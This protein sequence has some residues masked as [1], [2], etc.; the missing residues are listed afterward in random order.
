M[1]QHTHRHAQEPTHARTHT[2]LVLNYACG[3]S[4]QCPCWVL[5]TQSHLL[6]WCS[7]LIVVVLQ[8]LWIFQICVRVLIHRSIWKICTV[9]DETTSTWP[10]STL[11]QSALSPAGLS[12]STTHSVSQGN[13]RRF[14]NSPLKLVLMRGWCYYLY[15]GW[16]KPWA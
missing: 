2:R 13:S 1:H 3:P 16:V 11:I 10:L 6:S 9:G 7:P 4:N 5:S 15:W 14:S 12:P 8:V